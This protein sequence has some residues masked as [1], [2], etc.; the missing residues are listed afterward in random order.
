MPWSAHCTTA[1]HYST[2]LMCSADTQCWQL[3]ESLTSAYKLSN[4]EVCDFSNNKVLP[5]GT[6]KMDW[7]NCE[8]SHQCKEQINVNNL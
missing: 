6:Y 2:E 3:C 1:H 7:E 4:M 8:F 5:L